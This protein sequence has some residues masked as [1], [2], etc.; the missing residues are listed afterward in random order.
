MVRTAI[1]TEGCVHHGD[2]DRKVKV[3]TCHQ[4]IYVADI[5]GRVSDRSTYSTLLKTVRSGSNPIWLGCLVCHQKRG[6][7]I[8]GDLGF[9]GKPM[10]AKEVEI[11]CSIS[12]SFQGKGYATEAV[13]GLIRW[14][15]STG[16]VKKIIAQCFEDNHASIKVLAKI[17][18]KNIAQK[19]N[20]LQ[21]E[22]N[23]EE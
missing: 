12:P 17:G 4:R 10:S 9:K 18:M 3:S 20:I 15:A 6:N 2:S 14:A 21:W 8:I 5:P 23:L 19:Y 16:K 11:G 1:A 13:Q 22:I 7:K